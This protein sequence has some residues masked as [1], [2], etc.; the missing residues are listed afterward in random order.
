LYFKTKI[1]AQ[2][3]I[4]VKEAVE[5]PQADPPPQSLF[6][7]VAEKLRRL[8]QRPDAARAHRFLNHP[9]VF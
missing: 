1:T 3:A 5:L 7:L 6:L 9:T 4:L 2:A 8:R